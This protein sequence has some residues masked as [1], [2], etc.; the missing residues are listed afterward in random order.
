MASMKTKRTNKQIK[1]R[2]NASARIRIQSVTCS[3][4]CD[5]NITS[6]FFFLNFV[7]SFFNVI[8]PHNGVSFALSIV[9]LFVSQLALAKSE[10]CLIFLTG[11]KQAFATMLPVLNFVWAFVEAFFDL[12]CIISVFERSSDFDLFA[13]I[14]NIVSGDSD[15]E[16]FS[17]GN[18]QNQI[19]SH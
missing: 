14:A 18:L 8:F 3:D 12:L 9:L 7:L 1:R 2:K 11:F 15:V 6:F 19:Q 16:R 17:A 13:L 10:S 5:D 4:C